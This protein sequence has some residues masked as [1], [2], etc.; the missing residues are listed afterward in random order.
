M[1]FDQGMLMPATCVCRLTG[2]PATLD[3][4]LDDSLVVTE[5]LVVD[6]PGPDVLAEQ[7]RLASSDSCEPL[8][9]PQPSS[10]GRSMG[11]GWRQGNG[12]LE[13]V[14]VQ[15]WKP[16]YRKKDPPPVLLPLCMRLYGLQEI[17]T[18]WDPQ[19]DSKALMAWSSRTIL[20]AFRGT[21][22]LVNALID[23][24]VCTCHIHAMHIS[25]WRKG[26]ATGTLQDLSRIAGTAWQGACT[27]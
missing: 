24:K 15:G 1:H 19:R 11:D 22:S 17:K 27:S 14:V 25:C 16:Q 8:P 21:A 2:G 9:E 7:G 26:R 3:V 23:A 13:E 10:S 4:T 20:L 5:P 6:S 12:E 18:F